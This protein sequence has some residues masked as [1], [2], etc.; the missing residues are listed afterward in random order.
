MHNKYIIPGNVFFSL[1]EEQN[2]DVTVVITSS[3][4]GLSLSVVIFVGLSLI[5]TWVGLSVI[6]ISKMILKIHVW[7]SIQSCTHKL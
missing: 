1:G 5:G 3:S 6:V 4:V 2:G 7:S